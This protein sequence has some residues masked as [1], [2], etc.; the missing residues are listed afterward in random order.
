MCSERVATLHGRLKFL[1][2]LLSWLKPRIP[3]VRSNV[4]DKI[5][6]FSRSPTSGR[7][8]STLF[9]HIHQREFLASATVPYQVYF[10]H[11]S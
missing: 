4:P 9:T 2:A 1:R 3:T 10:I 5:V 6:V 8:Q 11:T 7:I